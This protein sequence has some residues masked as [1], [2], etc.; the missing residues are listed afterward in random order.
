VPVVGD[1][2]CVAAGWLRLDA[3][4]AAVFIA[5]GKLARYMALVA[6]WAWVRGE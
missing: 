5:T 4:A 6:G 3:A 1:G 2:L